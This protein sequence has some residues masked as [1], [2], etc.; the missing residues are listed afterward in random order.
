MEPK[1]RGHPAPSRP[2]SLRPRWTGNG[3]L[4]GAPRQPF[5]P[6]RFRNWRWFWDFGGGILTDLMV[7]WIDAVNW[8]LD[9]PDPAMA[10]T[11]GDTFLMDQWETPDTIQTLLRYPDREIQV[12]FE[13]TFVN[14]RKQS[15]GRNYGHSGHDVLGSWPI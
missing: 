4:G 6:F 13:G 8:M 7:H 1:P 9:L 15:Y 12:Y 2:R 10:T 14:Q 5:D 11:I 3:F